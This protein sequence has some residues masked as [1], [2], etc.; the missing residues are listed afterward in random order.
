VTEDVCGTALES[1]WL[2][3]SDDSDAPLA[4]P[5]E[6]PSGLRCKLVAPPASLPAAVIQPRPARRA[7]AAVAVAGAL[8]ALG[9]YAVVRRAATEAPKRLAASPGVAQVA[10]PRPEVPLPAAAPSEG[11][12]VIT[13]ESLALEGQVATE[14]GWGQPTAAARHGSRRPAPV[15]STAQR[16]KK[17]LLNPY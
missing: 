11:P 1:K 3:R 8:L 12:S 17:D 15:P 16:Q 9:T 10:A 7:T 4:W 14:P 5:A 2:A 6:A 13:P